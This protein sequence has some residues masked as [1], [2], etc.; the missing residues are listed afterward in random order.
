MKR[1]SKKIIL[2]SGSPRRKELLERLGLQFEVII[3]QVE[4]SFDL[5]IPVFDLVKKLAMQKA[6][7]VA[8]DQENAI[9]IGA[10]T[11]GV[12][13]G[14]ILSKPHDDT[15]AIR[16]LRM[17]NGRAHRVI[18][19]FTIMDTSNGHVVSD[20]VETTVYFR[21]LTLT[22]IEAYVKTGEPLD[23]AGAYAIQGLGA[24]I[25]DR[26]EGDYYNVMGLPLS[27][28][29][30]YLKLFGIKILRQVQEF[31]PSAGSC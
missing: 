23:K 24:L 22:E 26:I 10:D 31:K 25:V 13:R 28:V 5:D 18:T 7:T 6:L 21:K 12:Y 17:L 16:I 30:G 20:V 9:I 27:K 3:P 8:H 2:A 11:L 1:I 19:G 14:K 15:E 4:E 29:A